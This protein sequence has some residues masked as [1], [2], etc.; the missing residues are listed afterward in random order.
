MDL[1]KQ[2]EHG[3]GRILL[4]V[5]LRI[6]VLLWLLHA[7]VFLVFNALPDAAYSQLGAAAMKKELLE[8]TRKKMGL[9]GSLAHRYARS[10]ALTVRGDLGLS[11][12][13]G[14]PVSTLLQERAIDS[15]PYIL[16]AGLMAVGAM[17]FGAW[18]FASERVSRLQ[19]AVMF[20]AP[21]SALPQ[22]ATA[23]AIS[24]GALLAVAHLGAVVRPSLLMDFMTVLAIALLPA[25]LLFISASNSARKA[26]GLPYVMTYRAMGLPWTRI[27]GILQTNIL[28]E[29]VPLAN[30]AVISLLLGTVFA[31]LCFDRPGLG[32]VLAEAIRAGDQPMAAGWMLAVGAPTILC[33]QLVSAWNLRRPGA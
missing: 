15:L 18:W 2:N 13:S 6:I 28:W 33:S 1:S 12:R 31:E 7:A 5:T 3:L 11:I 10:L 24:S 20:L 26:I 22:F 19:Q 23:S 16:T 17:L 8:E 21:V 9:D 14:Y 29:M 25:G 32:S 30:R 4:V 27:R